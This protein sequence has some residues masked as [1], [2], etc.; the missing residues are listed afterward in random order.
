MTSKTLGW[1]VVLVAAA[2]FATADAAPVRYSYTGPEYTRFAHELPCGDNCFTSIPDGPD[3]INPFAG[4]MISGSFTVSS[5]LDD[6]VHFLSNAVEGFSYLFTDNVYSYETGGGILNFEIHVSGGSIEQWAIFLND[7]HPAGG[8]TA[9]WLLTQN[10]FA[11]SRGTSDQSVL[12]TTTCL[13][14]TYAAGCRATASTTTPTGPIPTGTWSMETL[15]GG[16]PFDPP[17]PPPVVPPVRVFE[18]SSLSLL[19]LGFLALVLGRRKALM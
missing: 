15:K 13:G 16:P 12:F 8:A 7:G 1:F 17:G 9:T 5:E 10:I 4:G 18:P 19:A 6:G 11:P 14:I 2:P 3:D